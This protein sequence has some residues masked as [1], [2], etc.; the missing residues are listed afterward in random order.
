MKKN[1]FKKL[2]LVLALAMIVSVIAPAAGVFA[3]AKPA[4][5]STKQYLYLSELSGKTEYDFNVNNKV[6]GAKYAWTSSNVAAATVDKTN[7]FTTA[8]GVGSTKVSVKI[9]DTK[10]KVTT[11]SADVIVRDNIQ[12]IAV[13]NPTTKSLKVLEAYDFNRSFVT[14]SGSTTKTSAIT[15]W[16]V[17]K[18]TATITDA[19]VFTA[20]EAGTYKVQAL[21]FQSSAKYE[22]WKTSKDAS[23]VL[24]TSAETTVTV[25]ATMTV[26]QTDLDSIKLTFDSAMTDVAKN[27]SLYVLVG[28]TEVAVTTAKPVTV[29]TDKKSATVDFYVAL[30]EGATYVVKYTG[31]ETVKFTA[32]KADPENV[33]KVVLKTTEGVV[34]KADP[35]EVQLFDA[36]SVEITKTALT[37]RVTFSTTATKG[38]YLDTSAKT[39]M[40]FTK[41]EIATVEAVFHTYKYE[42][43]KEI[44]NITG[45]GT[46]VGVDAASTIVGTVKAWTIVGRTDSASFS[47]VK[48]IIT[49]DEEKKLVVQLNTTTGTKTDTISSADAINKITFTSSDNSILF[50]DNTNGYL[51]PVKAGTVTV[52]IKKDD[53]TVDVITVTVGA[54]RTATS[55]VLG[56]TDVS[57][58]NAVAVDDSVNVSVKVKDQYGVDMSITS[59][60]IAINKLAGS[61]VSA[62][63]KVDSTDVVF[64]GVVAT[65]AADKGTYYYEVKAKGLTAYVTALVLAP[66]DATPSYKLELSATEIDNKSVKDSAQPSVKISIFGYAGGAKA[67]KANVTG[68]GFDV[69]VKDTDGKEITL[70]SSAYYDLTKA[71]VTVSGTALEALKAGVYTVTLKDKRTVASGVAID[72]QY[73]TVKN[74]QVKPTF[75]VV[76][77]VYAQAD[78]DTI[79]QKCFKVSFDG[80]DVSEFVKM[81]DKV[82]DLTTNIFVKNVKYTETFTDKTGTYTIVH[83]IDVNQ[84]LTKSN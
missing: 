56:K 42:A 30:T 20:T 48:Q 70:A 13:K 4:L 1:F 75:E 25:A 67:A 44:G 66:S 50:V 33:A 26:A 62:I 40:F 55:I 14:A 46:I 6:A 81:G 45:T 24:A 32:A 3:A 28:T 58:S 73:F 71:T 16:V 39:I 29:S 52:V 60:D 10:K 43:G 23:L 41:G 36:N 83:S 38:V 9:T 57:L 64:N 59:G 72:I 34:G 84:L 17:D 15:R 76:N 78:F 79:A 65:K 11:L 63:A 7:G 74:T 18:T 77:T 35:V 12:T 8:V 31:T 5:N 49:V 47:D 37:N 54:K 27:L 22:A 61:P 19:G 68:D 51:Y 80:K 21:A 69:V 53:K 82:G 2:S